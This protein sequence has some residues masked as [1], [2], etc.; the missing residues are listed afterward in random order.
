MK[1]LF[2]RLACL[3]NPPASVCAGVL[4]AF[5]S[6]AWAPAQSDPLAS[7]VSPEDIDFDSTLVA[8]DGRQVELDREMMLNALGLKDTRPHYHTWQAGAIDYHDLK[9]HRYFYRVAFRRP[10]A[11]GSIVFTTQAI[12][13]LK[14][15]APYPGDPENPDNWTPIEPPPHQH[16]T[17]IVTLPPG[18]TT[19]ALLLTDSLKSG[20]S[21]LSPFRLFSRRLHNIAPMASARAS[22]EYNAPQNF[23]GKLFAAADL[24]KGRGPWVSAGKNEEGNFTVPPVSDVAP[25]W[26]ALSWE[27]PV[28]IAGVYLQDNFTAIRLDSYNGPPG[29][30]PILGMDREWKLVDPSRYAVRIRNGRWIAFR[31]PISGRGLRLY[32]DNITDPHGRHL[33][34]AEIHQIM[35][36]EDLGDKPVPEPLQDSKPPPVSIP[37]PLDRPG[38]LTVA[39][40]DASGVRVRNLIAREEFD[41]G[42]HSIGWDLL[43][44]KAEYIRP[45]EYTWK[46]ITHPGLRL[47]YEFTV[48][49]NVSQLHPENSAWL[50][51]FSGPGGW[52]AD[53]SPPY[54]VCAGGGHVFVG[55]SCPEAGVGFAALNVSGRKL[56]GI[57]SFG[58]FSGARR[59]ATD[60][61]KV[62][63]ENMGI[64]Y[65]DVGFEH[66]WSVD[67]RTH[68]VKEL[69]CRKTN[70]R[71]AVGV[72]GMAAAA[73]RLYL[74]ICAKENSFLA[75]AGEEAV[76]ILNCL[77]RYPEPRPPKRPYEIVPNPRDDFLRLFRLKGAPPGYAP[78]HG[79]TYLE[80]TRGPGRRQHIVLAFKQPVA[81]G[82]C[83]FPVPLNAPYKVRLSALKPDA[84]YPPNA[85][86]KDHWLDFE[87]QA[88]LAW[89]VA[90][91]PTN[92]LTRALRITFISGEDDDLAEAIAED[93]PDV[94]NGPDLDLEDNRNSGSDLAG[95]DRRSWIGQLEGMKLFRRRFENLYGTAKISVSSG[96]VSRDGVW[97]AKRAEPLSPENPEWFVMEWNSPQ[98]IR[99]LAVKEIDCKLAEVD[100]W[101]GG[102][103]VDP[104]D[105]D[106]WKK[107]GQYT[108]RRRMNHPGFSGHNALA[109]YMDD[110]VDFG[111]DVSTRAVRIRVVE[112]WLTETREG[113]CAKDQLGIDPAR[114]RLFGV[115]PLRL[116]PGEAPVDPLTT[117][118]IEVYDDSG[119]A[120]KLAEEIHLK[121]PG[122]IAVD[123]KGRLLAFSGKSIARLENG[124]FQPLINDLAN[125]LSMTTDRDCSIYVFDAAPDRKVIRVY[126][127]RGVFLRSIGE[128]GGYE[129]GPWN[130][131]R[132]NSITGLAVDD[133]GFL[134]AADST[135]WPKRVSVWSLDGV[136]QREYLGPTEYGGGGTLDPWDKTRLFY[137][138]LEF[139]LDWEK[140]TSRLKSLTWICDTG[141]PAG[142][143]PIHIGDRLYMVTRIEA[144]ENTMPVG[145]VYLYEKQRLRPAAAMGFADAWKPLASPAFRRTLG[146]K[147]LSELQ[148]MWSDL[149]GN[150]EADIDEVLFE[151]RVIGRLTRFR[152]DLS[153]Q[154]GQWVFE[155]EKFLPGGVPVYRRRRV[156]LPIV[157]G[158]CQGE[159]YRLN[160]GC[161]YEMGGG[162]GSPEKW[163]SPDGKLLATY[164]NEG[165]AVGP[166]RSAGPYTPDQVVCQFGIIGHATAS[167]GD[168]GEFIVLNNNLGQWNVWTADGLLAARIFR[169]NRD[170]KR[171]FWQMPEHQRGLALDDLSQ[172]E[173][174]F[175]GCVCRVQDGRYYAVAGKAEASI[176]E[177]L[178][179]DEFKRIS[180]KIT[181]TEQ[182]IARTRLWEKERASM[183]AR[184]KIPVIDIYK[185]AFPVMIDG[186]FDDW[187]QTPG[188]SMND[189]VSFKAA[190]DDKALYVCYVVNGMGPFK[191][192]GS[193]W[194]HL[195]KSGACADLMIAADEN[196]DPQR[197]APAPG[198]KRVLMAIVQGKPMAVL[199]EPVTTGPRPETKW[200][201]SSPVGQ[202][203]FD[204]V[205]K[206]ENFQLA[207]ANIWAD[208]VAKT[209][210]RGYM[211]EARIPLADLGLQV[212]HGLRLKMDWGVLEADADGGMTVR[213]VYWANRQNMTVADIPSEARLEPD[214]W[215]WA[216]FHGKTYAPGMDTAESLLEGESP[217]EADRLLDD[218]DLE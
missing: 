32:T 71:R 138:P 153:T 90:I 186:V 155:V 1:T 54:G 144:A 94:R 210:L 35:V 172:L 84:P 151:D 181:V 149:N 126:D 59:M 157:P 9:G 13:F 131:N 145:I 121:D 85:D 164:K 27:K 188:V 135:Y 87:K 166:N 88:E 180:G 66:V 125:P 215:G 62:Y 14:P 218:L 159:C 19:R 67:V 4:L 169:D 130:P 179:M 142:E 146:R 25:A 214:M 97:I 100:V 192:S 134:W 193:R 46:A 43:D 75:A 76:D 182:D 10:V 104:A 133:N 114:C 195:F 109:L 92:T 47:R 53:H 28:E 89:D 22:M 80:S 128:P 216:R 36:L 176:V 175:N 161:Y 200:R 30:D 183:L 205:R 31:E 72:S 11:I 48:Y 150:G 217:A 127:E 209:G 139:E 213:R 34:N 141:S 40:D 201:A 206:I 96:V 6:A 18:F 86:R 115:A 111:S 122:E 41:A 196:A 15:G 83:V 3:N 5:L 65:D 79:L 171:I 38:L 154:S 2:S 61:R 118:R 37:I 106:H 101:T 57:H 156:D 211:V 68:E 108:P 167:G 95:S 170:P 82:S 168:L 158:W 77:P 191:N 185:A 189:Q 116:I 198:D 23:G 91:A 102:D 70:E 204:I 7:A 55:A 163:Y 177:I 73:G 194:D 20:R 99:G 49:P 29:L 207:A 173:E 140:G 24:V 74:S 98:T 112:Q 165:R 17:R 39:V 105:Q 197:K 190:Y 143:C 187:N 208:P 123:A 93:E 117:Q 119:D 107:V 64:A 8:A 120:L 78:G 137:G 129:A 44:E 152:N 63:V 56:W 199:Y 174:T 148:F 51:G 42:E 160:N 132:L 58:P 69:I 81:I 212:R 202:V 103:R 12:S 33:A 50:N 60:G 45:G 147:R 110:T 203:E 113:S 21:Y 178:G 52:L 136:F 124:R 162:R 16:Q 26:L 184:E